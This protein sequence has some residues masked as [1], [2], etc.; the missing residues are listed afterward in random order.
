MFRG[1]N[2][3]HQLELIVGVLGKPTV[4]SVLFHYFQALIVKLR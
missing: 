1:R 3:I 2:Y 4:V